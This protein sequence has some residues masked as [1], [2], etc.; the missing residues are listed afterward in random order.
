MIKKG[1]IFGI[2][3]AFIFSGCAVLP[4]YRVAREGRKMITDYSANKA[5]V[6][7][8]I[9]EHRVIHGMT[10]EEVME[11]WGPP[12]IEH[13][14]LINCRLYHSWAYRKNYNTRVLYFH[15]GILVDIK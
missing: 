9:K 5:A 6:A 14:L 8:A 7:R 12:E 15:R 2:L 1:V 11:S 4:S 3:M 13:E 10:M